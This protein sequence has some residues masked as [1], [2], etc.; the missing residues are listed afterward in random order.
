MSGDQLG[1]FRNGSSRLPQRETA[2]FQYE[3][4]GKKMHTPTKNVLLRKVDLKFWVNS[5]FRGLGVG[6]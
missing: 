3:S 2:R 6:E 1:W 4:G 5:G